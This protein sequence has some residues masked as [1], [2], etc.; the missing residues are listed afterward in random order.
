ML[1]DE[2]RD[3]LKDPPTKL[4]GGQQR[5]CLARVLA[6]RPRILLLD[7]PTA[8]IDVHNTVKIEEALKELVREEGLT[9]VL[10]THMPSQA[11]RVGDYVAILYDGRIEEFGRAKEVCSAPRTEAGRRVLSMAG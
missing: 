6:M 4:S 8:N 7:E 2:V 11:R 1:W 9:I 3:R 10:V 5:L